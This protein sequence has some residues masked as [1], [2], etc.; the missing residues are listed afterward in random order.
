MKCCCGR[1]HDI[2]GKSST[3]LAQYLKSTD[4]NN[5]NKDYESRNNKMVYPIFR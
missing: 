1:P 2:L 3:R 4:R 5:N